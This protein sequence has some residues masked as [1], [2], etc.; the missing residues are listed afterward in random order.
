MKIIEEALVPTSPPGSSI[1]AVLQLMEGHQKQISYSIK[2]Y[3]LLQSILIGIRSYFKNGNDN[4]NYFHLYTGS[5]IPEKERR[6][7]DVDAMGDHPLKPLVLECLNDKASKRPTAKEIIKKLGKIHQ[8]SDT[9]LQ[10]E[11]QIK[12]NNVPDHQQSEITSRDCTRSHFEKIPTQHG[13]D[14]RFKILLIGNSG[15]GKTCLVQKLRNPEYNHILSVSTIGIEPYRQAFQYN[16]KTVE[17]QITDTAGQ[18]QFFSIQPS[19]FRQIEGM[20]LVYDVLSEITFRKLPDWIDFAKQYFSKS[21][22]HVVVV[23]NKVDCKN[24][25][26]GTCNLFRGHAYIISYVTKHWELYCSLE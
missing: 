7:E 8:K 5:K 4:N 21:C 26:T 11:S 16:F 13:Y 18:E 15:V 6:K 9:A 12:T 17:L 10:V 2:F 20:F 23:G 3:L 1:P 24:E 19:Y 25:G 14:Y 22:V